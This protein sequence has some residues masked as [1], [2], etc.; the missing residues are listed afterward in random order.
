MNDESTPFKT[1]L[2]ETVN[3]TKLTLSNFD[4]KRI[5]YDNEIDT[6]PYGHYLLDELCL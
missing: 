2:V 6:L 4:D 3:L 1:R 5:V